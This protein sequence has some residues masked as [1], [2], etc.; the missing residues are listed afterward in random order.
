ML[1]QSAQFLRYLADLERL[2]ASALMASGRETEALG[3][4]A[5]S[6]QHWRDA[7]GLDSTCVGRLAKA[8]VHQA[9]L[10]AECGRSSQA[11]QATME[12]DQLHLFLASRDP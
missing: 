3:A 10:Q 1:E 12:S 2:Q 8:L 7:H 6:V 9:L 4:V 5:E 11:L